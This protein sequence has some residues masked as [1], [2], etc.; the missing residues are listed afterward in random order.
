MKVYRILPAVILAIPLLGSAGEAGKVQIIT[1]HSD[2]ANCIA[3]LHV[4]KIDGREAAVQRMGFWIEPGKHSM[5]GSAVVDASFCKTIG[6]SFTP[7][8]AELLDAEF[9]LGKVYYVGYDHSSKDKDD[10]KIVIWKVKDAK[11]D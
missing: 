6:S 8:R 11:T 2:A 4:R 5:S 1:S 10:W 3:P 9:E 7:P